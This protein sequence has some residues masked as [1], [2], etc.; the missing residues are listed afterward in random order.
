MRFL[1]FG[2]VVLAS[3]PLFADEF[4]RTW[5]DG[6]AEL[7]GYALT[8]PRYGHLR[9]G[10][11]VMVFVT[12]DFSESARVKADPGKHPKSE[13]HPVLKLNFIRDFQTGIY[14][15]NVMTS[16]FVRT[17]FSGADLWPL[18]KTSFSS[19]EW[20]GQVYMQWIPRGGELVGVVHSYFDGEE[21][22]P[23]LPL[24]KGGVLEEQIPI[25]IRGLRGPWL[26]PGE[27]RT[28]PFLPSQLHARL[29][30]VPAAWGEATVERA[31]RSEKVE[32][33]KSVLG[34]LAADSYRI[35]VRGG[36]TTTWTV[37]AAE[38]HRILAWKST[39]G[40]AGQL[41]GSQRLVYWEMNQPGG[42]K[43]LKALGLSPLQP[44]APAGR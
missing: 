22:E 7:D 3:A 5:G 13:V 31:P 36:D 10:T 21:A 28:L 37:E 1:A 2:V 40:E 15:Y 18:D 6:K 9:A 41:T 20:C 12:E 23:R 14:D 27:K 4:W 8:Q 19:Q 26:Q 33:V 32:K 24:P 44:A 35:A 16:T 25:L 42:E 43:A 34:E 30:H 11:A 38:P 39:S 17:E 29:Q